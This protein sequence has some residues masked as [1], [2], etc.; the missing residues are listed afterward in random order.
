MAEDKRNDSQAE[1]DAVFFARQ[2]TSTE[3]NRNPN[4]V[5]GVQENRL[6]KFMPVF[7]T[8]S[9]PVLLE[10]SR[11]IKNNWYDSPG[12]LLNMCTV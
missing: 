7:V 8:I 2:N 9:V 5:E 11:G 6:L 3:M 4:H 12:V 1:I 10:L